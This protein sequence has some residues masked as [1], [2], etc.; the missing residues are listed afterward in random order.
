MSA[1]LCVSVRVHVRCAR[2]CLVVQDFADK[3]GRM[4]TPAKVDVKGMPIKYL[5]RKHTYSTIY[6]AYVRSVRERL[7]LVEEPKP[8]AAAAAGAGA[9]AGAPPAAGRLRCGS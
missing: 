4:H 9:G 8:D 6:E 7:G 3:H 1:T 2:V 5:P